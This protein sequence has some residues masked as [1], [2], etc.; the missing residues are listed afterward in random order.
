ML[1][2]GLVGGSGA[3]A[4]G[5][6]LRDRDAEPS[7]GCDAGATSLRPPTGEASGRAP[8]L[9]RPGGRSVMRGTEQGVAEL[10]PDAGSG[11]NIRA[12]IIP[13]F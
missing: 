13:Y 4:C 6:S 9:R 8:L 7:Y 10:H 3:E 2:T 5:I 12:P 1:P 11:L